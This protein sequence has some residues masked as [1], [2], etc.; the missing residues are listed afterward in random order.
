MDMVLPIPSPQSL[1]GRDVSY[2]DLVSR[3]NLGIS[4]MYFRSCK[5]RTHLDLPN[6]MLTMYLIE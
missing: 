6:P 1:T 3:S 2:S 5:H 4:V